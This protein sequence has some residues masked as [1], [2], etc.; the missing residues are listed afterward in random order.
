MKVLLPHQVHSWLLLSGLEASVSPWVAWADNSHP[1]GVYNA[2]SRLSCLRA[3]W[4]LTSG[5]AVLRAWQWAAWVRFLVV[6]FKATHQT[7]QAGSPCQAREIRMQHSQQQVALAHNSGTKPS[8]LLCAAVCWPTWK[9]WLM[10]G[11]RWPHG[12][13]GHTSSPGPV[14]CRMWEAQHAH[15][16]DAQIY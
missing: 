11:Q 15:L 6:P 2:R 3:R 4:V 10:L 12:P 1:G 8:W 16:C 7:K 5:L 14:P 13:H 9:C